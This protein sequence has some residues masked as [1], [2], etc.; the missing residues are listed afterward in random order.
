MIK[1]FADKE[2]QRFYQTGKSRRIP[3]E[4]HRT[5]LRK[6]DYLAMAHLLEDLRVPPG[7][8]L[9]AL[10]GSLRGRYSIR[11]NR[12]YRIIFG[13]DAGDAYDVTIVDYH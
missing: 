11:I 1:S 13:F 7:N 8:M 4:I 10:S 5:A 2:T 3:P 9:E 6:L 12:Q